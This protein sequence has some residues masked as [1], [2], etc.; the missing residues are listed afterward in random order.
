MDIALKVNEKTLSYSDLELKGAFRLR[1]ILPSRCGLILLII[2]SKVY[3][4]YQTMKDF[5]LSKIGIEPPTGRVWQNSLNLEE[6]YYHIT[7]ICLGSII[8]SE[9][10]LDQAN[11]Y[12]ALLPESDREMKP[13]AYCESYIFLSYST[14]Y[15]AEHYRDTNNSKGRKIV[16]RLLESSDCR[17]IIS[18]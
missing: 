7:E 6:S 18:R 4:I 15:W 13:N 10:Q 3:F 11:L 16:E 2:E 12:N 14:I 9:I 1:E 8:F 17:S 5:L